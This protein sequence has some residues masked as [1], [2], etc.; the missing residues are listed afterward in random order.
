MTSKPID[1]WDVETFDH[2][3]RVELEA[4]KDLFCNYEQTE[5]INYREQ[6]ASKEWIPQKENPYAADRQA[7]LEENIMPMMAQRI[8]RAW[9]YT[10]LTDDE[11]DLLKANGIYTSDLTTI[12][13]RLDTQV[14]AGTISAKIA[15]ALYGSSPFYSQ[16]EARSGKFW[17]TSHPYHPN[18]HGVELLLGHWGGEGVYFWLEDDEHIKLVQGIGRPRVV[19]IAIPLSLTT[20]AYPAAKAVIAA[21]VKVHGCEPDGG[22]FDLY[23]NSALGADAVLN[24]LTEGGT[25]FGSLARGYPARFTDQQV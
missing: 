21:F 25:E 6:Q 19:E 4:M 22:A 17:M 15:D 18:H 10:R 7:I 1:V 11:A 12:R 2:A 9:H 3:L 5:K 24:V 16:K 13:K 23:A 20:S 14:A 8:I